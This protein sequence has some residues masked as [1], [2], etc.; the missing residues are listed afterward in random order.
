MGEAEG[1]DQPDD[2]TLVSQTKVVMENL[3]GTEIISPSSYQMV[4]AMQ[5][6]KFFSYI[7]MGSNAVRCCFWA[8][9][10]TA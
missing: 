10:V 5:K 9:F 6:L 8:L 7:V 3:Q 1:Q 2:E 4:H